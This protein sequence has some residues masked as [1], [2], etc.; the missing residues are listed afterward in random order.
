M[1]MTKCKECKNLISNT[2]ANCPHCGF[3][4]KKKWSFIKWIGLFIAII[5]AVNIFKAVLSTTDTGKQ[6]E[7]STASKKT[8]AGKTNTWEYSKTADVVSGKDY[9]LA[10]VKSNNK[11]NLEFPYH[12]GTVGYL[13][14]RDHPRYG[15]SV[16][17][18]VNKGQILC[19][20]ISSCEISIKFDDKPPIKIRASEPDDR[21]SETLFLREYDKLVTELKQSKRTVI[22]ITFF[23]QGSHA[24]IFSTDGLVWN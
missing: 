18:Q 12:G 3:V 15:K 8:T 16:M 23:R 24:F 1:A 5:L 17:F 10:S 19:S 11:I 4:L 22:E 9:Q 20:S 14:V 13:A 2:A 21:S 6:E 7:K